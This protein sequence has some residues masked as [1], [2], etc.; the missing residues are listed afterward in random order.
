LSIHLGLGNYYGDVVARERDGKYFLELDNWDGT[1]KI[2]ISQ[3][4]FEMI[5]KEFDIE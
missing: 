4:L 5:K 2:E 1:G 3:E